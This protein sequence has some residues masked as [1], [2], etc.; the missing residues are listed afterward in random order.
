DNQYSDNGSPINPGANVDSPG[1]V[2]NIDFGGIY[3]PQPRWRHMN[4]TVCNFL[5]CD[6]HVE[7]RHYKKTGTNTGT[8]DLLRKNVNVNAP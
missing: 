6:G 7:S 4:N 5:F 3:I 8:C 1:D 2:K